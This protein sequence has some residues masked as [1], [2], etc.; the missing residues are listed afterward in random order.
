MRFTLINN[1]KQNKSMKLLLNGLLLFIVLYLI[2]D[3]FVKEHTLG[4]STTAVMSTLFGNEEEFLDPMNK[5]VF[6]EYIHTE[7]FFLMMILVTLSSV[8][9]RLFHK[10][11]NVLLH[12]NLLMISALLSLLTLTI[13]YFYI[14]SFVN[15]YIFCFFI[16]HLVALYIAL[17]SSWELNLA[18]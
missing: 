2:F 6:L 7:I 5:S 12:V 13:S 10:K 14:A 18:K 8:Y 9:I 4:L 16:W 1:L 17:K 3:I 11:T 15:I